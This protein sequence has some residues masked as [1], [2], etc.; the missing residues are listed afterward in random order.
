MQYD[1]VEQHF[2]RWGREHNSFHGECDL[3]LVHSKDFH[4]GAGLDLH[5]RTTIQDYFSF[6]E[7]AALRVG[8]N[9]LQVWSSEFVLNGMKHFSSDLPMTFGDKFKY[10]IT[11]L[12]ASEGQNPKF[13][14]YYMVDLNGQSHIIFKFYKQYLT[15]SVSGSQNDFGDS[16]GLMGEYGSGEMI[17]RDGNVISDFSQFGFEW[18]VNPTD[19]LLF[20]DTRQP[21]LPF[22][23]CRMP[24][25]ARPVRRHLR[26]NRMLAEQAHVACA[27]VSGSDFELCID[28]VMQTNDIGLA[29]TW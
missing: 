27:H 18:Q 12:P 2:Q 6:I 11:E 1:S 14:K 23:A 29:G 28:D 20:T 25:A 22:E 10:T 17:S 19:P 9:K 8:E 26:A 7:T 15:I 13:Y 24:T 5:V 3:V 4:E 21:Q 16:D